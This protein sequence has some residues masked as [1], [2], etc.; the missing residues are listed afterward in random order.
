MCF[1]D[2]RAWRQPDPLMLDL[3]GDGVELRRADGPILFDHDAD[4]IRTGTGWLGS[5]ATLTAGTTCT[6]T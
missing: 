1:R 2:A 3:D 5:D 6:T 4:T